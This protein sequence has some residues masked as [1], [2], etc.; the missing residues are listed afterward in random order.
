MAKLAPAGRD[1]DA[2]EIHHPDPGKGN[3]RTLH[4]DGGDGVARDD[5]DGIGWLVRWSGLVGGRGDAIRPEI[6]PGGHMRRW[7]RMQGLEAGMDGNA[8]GLGLP[9]PGDAFGL[10]G[11]PESRSDE[12]PLG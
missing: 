6:Q 11:F 3:S 8:I 12:G 4:K 7:I 2:L 5:G 1:H 9:A 10:D